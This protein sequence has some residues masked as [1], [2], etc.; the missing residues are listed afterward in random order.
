MARQTYRERA[1]SARIR[2]AAVLALGYALSSAA[3]VGAQTHTPSLG[4]L[5]YE[6]GAPLHRVGLTASS[7]AAEPVPGGSTVWG[8]RLAYSNIFEQDST[9][10]HVLMVD[11][12]RLLSTAYARFGLS[13]RVEV[14]GSLTFETT[15][16]GA[17]DGFVTWWHTRLGAGNA[18]RERFPEDAYD[19]RLEQPE[20]GTLLD[21]PRRTLGL[22]EARLFGKWLLAGSEQAPG[23]LSARMTAR[24]PVA[25][26]DPLKARTDVGISLLGRLSKGGWHAHSVVGATTVRTTSVREANLLRGQAYHGMVGVERSMGE[27]W[28]ALVQYHYGS[29]LFRSFEHRE[30]DGPSMNLVVGVAGRGGAHWRWDVSFQED[31]PPDTPAADFAL[32]IRIARTW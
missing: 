22:E 17:L 5:A 4:P 12:E 18:N 15:G 6:D 1:R 19:Q 9:A 7:E 25:R 8:L 28:A 13:D 21:V 31:L 11:M 30:L 29:P 27:G 3:A 32:G 16:P 2:I 23:A 14:G 10:H 24:F 20:V 26:D